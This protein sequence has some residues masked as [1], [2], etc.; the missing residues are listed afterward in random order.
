M[1]FFINAEVLVEVDNDFEVHEGYRYLDYV[2]DEDDGI[3]MVFSKKDSDEFFRV[4]IKDSTQF[5]HT[6]IFTI[7]YYEH[8]GEPMVEVF[9]IDRSDVHP[10]ALA[11][12][13]L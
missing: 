4:P 2:D 9:R 7:A 1:S 10:E 3:W 6:S 13:G 11:D 8:S 12:A 5:G